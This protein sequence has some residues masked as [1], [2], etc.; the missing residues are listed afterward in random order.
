MPGGFLC[1]LSKII[2][3]GSLFVGSPDNATKLLAFSE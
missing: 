3:M 1:Y 2:Y